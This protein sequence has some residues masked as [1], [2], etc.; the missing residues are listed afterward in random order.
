[1]SFLTQLSARRLPQA[2]NSI[3]RAFSTTSARDLARLSLIGRLGAA[4]ELI[5]TGNGRELIKYVVA[6]P[7]GPTDSEGNRA[8]SWFRVSNFNISDEGSK[9]RNYLTSLEKG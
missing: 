1:M 7:T 2:T 6:V 3:R 4:P 5:T 9:G 8:T